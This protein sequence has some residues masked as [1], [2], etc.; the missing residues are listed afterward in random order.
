MGS[1]PSS[2]LSPESG[3]FDSPTRQIDSRNERADDYE[4]SVRQLQR[5]RTLMERAESSIQGLMYSNSSNLDFRQPTR[6]SGEPLGSLPERF[7]TSMDASGTARPHERETHP[8]ASR[9]YSTDSPSGVAGASEN[10]GSSISSSSFSNFLSNFNLWR[11]S[12]QSTSDRQRAQSLL[13]MPDQASNSSS[14]HSSDTNHGTV[15]RHSQDHE[16]FSLSNPR[17]VLNRLLSSRERDSVGSNDSNQR[18]RDTFSVRDLTFATAQEFLA[19]A[20]LNGMGRVYV[21]HSLPTHMWAVNG[22][23]SSFTS[24]LIL[25]RKLF[26]HQFQS[27]AITLKSRLN[28]FSCLI[29]FV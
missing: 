6:G 10:T 5:E 27:R 19:E 13:N 12:A 8:A 7:S 15:S 11:A 26:I 21:T 28:C 29:R 3:D 2:P 20:T 18:G 16:E 24:I 25:Y 14:S 1:K 17:D 4:S 23:D 22:I 9:S